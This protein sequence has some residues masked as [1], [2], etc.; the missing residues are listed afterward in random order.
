MTSYSDLAIQAHTAA[1]N[2]GAHEPSGPTH[3]PET[4]KAMVKNSI[5]SIPCP[6]TVDD[7][8]RSHSSR[9]WVRFFSSTIT[10]ALVN[11]PTM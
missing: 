9:P 10:T 2:T 6:M 8:V 7:M 5:E 4:P 3:S 1:L 11:S